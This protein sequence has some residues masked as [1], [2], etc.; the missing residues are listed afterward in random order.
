MVHEPLT[1]V[2]QR[3]FSFSFGAASRWSECEDHQDG[4]QEFKTLRGLRPTNSPGEK[5]LM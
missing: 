4:N 3:L 1:K 2:D 5:S